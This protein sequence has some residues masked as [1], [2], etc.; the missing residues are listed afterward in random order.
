MQAWTRFPHFPGS[1]ETRF[2]PIAPAVVAVA[3]L[4][5]TRYLM[6]AGSGCA[7]AGGG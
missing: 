2:R 1:L 7:L 3:A 4:Q 6:L 5:R